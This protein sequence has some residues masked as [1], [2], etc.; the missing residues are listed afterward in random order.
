M[1]HFLQFVLVAVFLALPIAAL[2][3]LILDRFCPE[4][5]GRWLILGAALIPAMMVA[6]ICFVEGHSSRY[7]EGEMA[8]LLYGVFGTPISLMLGAY[9][10]A[11]TLR[12]RRG[13]HG[14]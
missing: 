10:A 12:W 13:G 3:V 8:A 14:K 4:I 5:D 9:S 6:V 2:A 11:G 7:P 1:N